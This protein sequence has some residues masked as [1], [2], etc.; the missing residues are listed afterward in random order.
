M[1]AELN[2]RYIVQSVEHN[3]SAGHWTVQLVPEA[4]GY[5]VDSL[6]SPERPDFEPGQVVW[7]RAESV[8]AR[9]T[10]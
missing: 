2:E 6:R 3:K 9:A 10:A 1:G 7:I 8:W 5:G 4:G